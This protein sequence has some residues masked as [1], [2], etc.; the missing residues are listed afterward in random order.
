[1]PWGDGVKRTQEQKRRTDHVQPHQQ[2]SQDRLTPHV[3]QV[4]G[5]VHVPLSQLAST[6]SSR[7]GSWPND[8]AASPQAAAGHTGTPRAV[9]NVCCAQAN[10]PDDHADRAMPSVGQERAGPRASGLIYA[11][12]HNVAGLIHRRYESAR[13]AGLSAVH[14]PPPHRGALCSDNREGVLCAVICALRCLA[15]AG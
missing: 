7:A 8:R 2:P 5:A 3:P 9:V 1:M 12:L 6:G 4:L 14:K 11:A 10:C 15:P 13:S